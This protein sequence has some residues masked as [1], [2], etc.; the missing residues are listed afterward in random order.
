MKLYWLKAL[1]GLSEQIWKSLPLQCY[2]TCVA[3]SAQLAEVMQKLQAMIDKAQSLY[4]SAANAP[5]RDLRSKSVQIC[6]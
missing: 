1:R 2:R 4:S 6:M 5:R 3:L